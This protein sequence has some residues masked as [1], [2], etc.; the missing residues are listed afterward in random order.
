M[1]FRQV[2]PVSGA[3]G[4]YLGSF[5]ILGEKERANLQGQSIFA[6]GIDTLP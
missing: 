4:N 5:Q 3:S 1:K 6:N 2:K